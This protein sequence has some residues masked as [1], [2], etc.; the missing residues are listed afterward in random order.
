MQRYRHKGKNLVPDKQG[1][2][3]FY[4]EFRDALVREDDKSFARHEGLRRGI[5]L[6]RHYEDTKASHDVTMDHP[7]VRPP[8]KQISNFEAEAMKRYHSES[9]FHGQVE[10]IMNSIITCIEHTGVSL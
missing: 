8:D 9:A 10:T 3:I 7:L 1:K 2:W 5:I 4:Q 6:Q